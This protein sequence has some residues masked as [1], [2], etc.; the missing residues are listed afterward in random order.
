[1]VHFQARSWRSRVQL[2]AT[3]LTKHLNF[4]SRA[5]LVSS[6]LALTLVGTGKR[7]GLFQHLEAT[8]LDFWTRVQPHQPPD[9]RL[10]LVEITEEDLT[11]Y[12]WPLSDQR[13]ADIIATL[14]R[15]NP[16]VIGLDLYRSTPHSPGREALA[17]EFQAANLIGIM[18]AGSQP[19][20]GEVPAPPEWP[21][22]QVG[23]N[24]LALDPD[25]VLR[26]NLLFVGSPTNPYYSFPL[27]VVLAYHPE[28]TF[29]VD[30]EEDRLLIGDTAFPALMAGDG[31]YAKIDHRGYQ[32]L[33]RYRTPYAPAQKITVAQVL[34]GVLPANW[35]EGK[36]VLIGSTASSLKDE[37]F[38]PYSR[39]QSSRF[40]MSGVEVHA[41]SISQLLDAIAGERVL[42]RFL[43][44]WGE[45]LWLLAVV[46]LGSGLGWRIR[47]PVVLVL[48]VSLV[49]LGIWGMGG[50]ALGQLWWIPTI[51]P[52]AG[53]LLAVGLV[54]AQ[55]ALYRTSYDQLTLLPGREIFLLHIQRELQLQR[56]SELHPPLT[57]VF[58]DIDRFKL[59]NQSFGHTVGDRVLQTMAKRLLQV[60]PESAQLARV[61]GDE[62]AFLLPNNDQSQVDQLLNRVQEEL[63]APIAIAKQRLSITCSMG[64]AIARDDQHPPQPEELL[65]DAHTAMYRAKALNEDRYEVFAVTM[66]EEAV[67]RLE[68]ESHLLNAFENQEFLLHYQPI[69]NLYQGHLIGFEALVRWYRPGE[70]FVAPGQF[71]QVA[72]ETGLI[73]NLGQWIFQEASRQLKVWQEQYPHL[74]LKMSIN[75][76]RRQFH[77]TDLVQQFARCLEELGVAGQQIQLEI[78]ESMIMRNVEAAR[79]LMHQLKGLGLQLAIDDFGTGYSS[80]SYLHR[81]PTDTL[82]VDQSFVGRM[83]QS[84]DDREIVHT[85]IALGQ[86][87]GMTLV[88]EGIETQRQI[89][90]L[91]EMGCRQGQGYFFSPP[92]NPEQATALMAAQLIAP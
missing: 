18:N 19:D 78:T 22:D 49:L 46:L 88:A 11:T 17:Q 5:I 32:I 86:K 68:L 6:L 53:F 4:G 37:F 56:R 85:I 48:G 65:R 21:Q 20:G 36:V 15:Y 34:S 23:F 52:M 54:V 42:Y 84:Q 90:L 92:L 91:L 31:G 41:Q 3:Q 61:G 57:V 47:R 29:Q 89:D 80:L 7:L 24:D 74:N 1:M 40:M 76:S 35:V 82:K 39:D 87:L 16:A 38:T 28:L 69:V 77:Q 30:P 71:I 44:Q 13:V 59:I 63:A 12:G 26:R 50:V 33:K 51:E 64:M 73:I 58:L 66:R 75:L 81:F 14:Q 2:L 25:G 45:F 55:K 8:N 60:L 70:G 10:L 43:P 62:F 83:D 27:R 67:R 9:D 72:E 79:Q